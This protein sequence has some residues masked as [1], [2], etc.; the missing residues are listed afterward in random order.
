MRYAEVSVNSPV[1]QRR[2]FSYEIPPGLN[3]DVGQAVWVPFGEKTLQGVVLELS[4]YPTVEDTREIIDV[5]DPRPLLSSAHV[6]LARWISE[7]YLSSLFDA[8][9]LML[10]P[11]FERKALTFVSIKQHPEAVDLSSFSQEQKQVFEFIHKRGNASL[12]E[13]E[14]SL[15][16]QKART[17]VSYLVGRGLAIRRYELEPV[18]I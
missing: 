4:P 12:R 2:I 8:V 17:I 7:H 15:G 16:K 1:A 14:K 5:F 13:L 6:S 11:G 10:P 18:R 3:I 9:A